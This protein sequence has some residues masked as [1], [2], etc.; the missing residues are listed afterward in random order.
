M[1][2]H[3]IVLAPTQLRTHGRRTVECVGSNFQ[4]DI[5][6]PAMADSLVSLSKEAAFSHA[7]MNFALPGGA[8]ALAA[9]PD[10]H[11][12]YP[13]SPCNFRPAVSAYRRSGTIA[14]WHVNIALSVYLGATLGLRRRKGS[15]TA[16]RSGVRR[17]ALPLDDFSSKLDPLPELPRLTQAEKQRLRHGLPVHRQERRGGGGWGVVVVDVN[18]SNE[19]VFGVLEAFEDYGKVIPTVRDVSLLS[20]EERQEGVSFV[21]CSYLLSRFRLK[22]SAVHLVDKL[23]KTVRFDLDPAASGGL[24]R[25]ASGSWHVEKPNDNPSKSRIWFRCRLQATSW[26]PSWLVEYGSQRALRRATSWLKP[27]V[28]SLQNRTQVLRRELTASAA[29]SPSPYSLRLRPAV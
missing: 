7:P 18:A 16:K 11:N 15:S 12:E 20:R 2:P 8:S 29:A 23:A 25:E 5:F 6:A 19:T 10:A 4:F 21:R 3:A 17:E 26:V 27:H 1:L 13:P 24:L 22:V 28:E 9:A 14:W